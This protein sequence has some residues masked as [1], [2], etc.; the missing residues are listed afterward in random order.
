MDR[1]PSNA[2]LIGWGSDPRCPRDWGSWFKARWIGYAGRMTTRGIVLISVLLIAAITV[3]LVLTLGPSGAEDNTPTPDR[4][5]YL[6]AIDPGHGGRDPGAV[7]E[8]L[9]EKDI[10]LAITVVLRQL[11]DAEPD[12][13]AVPIRTQD[14]FLSLEDR[15]ARAENAGAHVYVTVHVNAFTDERP[16]GVETLVDTTRD[17][18]DDSWV[19][20]E[21]IQRAVVQATGA[22]DRGVRTQESYLQRTQ[23]PAV[24]VE[25]GYL[26]HPEERERLITAEYQ[27]RIAEGI[28]DGIRAFIDWRYPADDAT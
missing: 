20:A 2:V 22:R 24:S 12:M 14:V 21:L 4:P 13:R 8:D 5:E 23:I 10:N 6:I 19:L 27:R 26:T 9:L 3:T 25:T 15:I 1:A 16:E 28:R 7:W 18:S 11:V 17:P